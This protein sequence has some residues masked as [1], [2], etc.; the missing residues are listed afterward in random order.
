MRFEIKSSYPPY[1]DSQLLAWIKSH[2]MGFRTAFPPR[3]VNNVYFDTL[4]LRALDDNIAGISQRCKVRYRWY[5]HNELPDQGTLEFKNKHTTLGWKDNF[6]VDASP[7]VAGDTWR[8]FQRKLRRALPPEARVM[9]DEHGEVTLINRYDRRY[10]ESHDR[11]LRITLDSNQSMYDQMRSPRPNITRRI[12]LPDV[13]IL[14]LKCEDLDRRALVRA[15]ADCP[16]RIA[17]FSKYS[18]GSALRD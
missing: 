18:A 15:L 11:K 7:Y 6:R 3:R 12:N 14:E 2:T 1:F 8:A 9:L 17:R 10:F 16:V 4:D 13:N 5:G